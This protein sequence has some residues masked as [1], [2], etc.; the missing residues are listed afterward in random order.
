MPR[1]TAGQLTADHLQHLVTVSAETAESVTFTMQTLDTVSRWTGAT[2][3]VLIEGE[4]LGQPVS[5]ALPPWHP[6]HVY[7]DD[8]SPTSRACL[9][10]I[11]EYGEHLRDAEDEEHDDSDLLDTETDARITAGRNDR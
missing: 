9:L 4:A 3:A 11:T 7:L 1:T 8:I 2:D 6:V 10:S 5:L